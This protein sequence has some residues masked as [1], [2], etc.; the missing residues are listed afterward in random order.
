MD[1]W[2]ASLSSDS[3]SVLPRL[4][5][6]ALL[7]EIAR[8]ANYGAQPRSTESETLGQVSNIFVLM[9]CSGDSEAY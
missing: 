1:K 8:N 4:A 6:S 7:G 3:Q 9:S 2:L 5:I